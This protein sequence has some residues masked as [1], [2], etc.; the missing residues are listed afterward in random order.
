MTSWNSAASQL[1]LPDDVVVRIVHLR[2][3]MLVH[4][5]LY[6]H[7]NDSVVDD[8]QWQA[9]ANELRDLQDACAECREV[10][11]YDDHFQDWDGSTGYHLPV[12]EGIQRAARRL[13]ENPFLPRNQ[14]QQPPPPKL[15]RRSLWT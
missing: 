8:H 12:D 11:F 14:S 13:L 1:Y 3:L 15:K 10:G 6:Y 9:W 4:S 2:R 7:A 5:Y